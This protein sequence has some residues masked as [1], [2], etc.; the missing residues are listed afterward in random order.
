MEHIIKDIEIKL[1]K[2]VEKHNKLISDHI[3]L[4][5]ENKVISDDLKAKNDKLLVL[6]DKINLMKISKSVD[7]SKE[8]IK[9]T[10][11]KINEYVREIDQ[12]IALLNK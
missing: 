11:L 10:R 1:E 6:Q 5:Q 9:S 4:K 8:E 12:C 3:I 2:F 7:D